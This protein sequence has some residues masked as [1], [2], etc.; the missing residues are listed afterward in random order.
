MAATPTPDQVKIQRHSDLLRYAYLG[1]DGQ[2][3]SI[4]EKGDRI[5]VALGTPLPD[6]GKVAALAPEYQELADKTAGMLMTLTSSMTA[7]SPEEKG[8]LQQYFAFNGEM[9]KFA[10]EQ[11]QSLKGVLGKVSK[12]AG[13]DSMMPENPLQWMIDAQHTAT[14]VAANVKALAKLTVAPFYDLFG[15]G[16]N[17][18]DQLAANEI[19]QENAIAIAS[20]YASARQS[21]AE[22]RSHATPL[23]YAIGVATSTSGWTAMVDK[24]VDGVMWVA[25]P[26]MKFLAGLVASL[27]DFVYPPAAQAVRGWINAPIAREN[28]SFVENY[29][30]N[31]RGHDNNRVAEAM[32]TMPKIGGIATDN[33]KTLATGGTVVTRDRTTVVFKPANEAQPTP[34]IAKPTDG[35]LIATPPTPAAAAK[36]NEAH[37]MQSKTAVLLNVANTTKFDRVVETFTGMKPNHTA[38]T[39]AVLG[40]GGV[41]AA[42]TGK[43]LVGGAIEGTQRRLVHAPEARAEAAAKKLVTLEKN[44]AKLEAKQVAGPSKK[45]WFFWDASPETIAARQAKIDADLAAAE[46]KVA[47]TTATLDHHVAS[48]EARAG[49]DF[50]DVKPSAPG[51]EP[52]HTPGVLTKN[53][54]E[55]L[56]WMN[57]LNWTRIAARRVSGGVT[58]IV[59]FGSHQAMKLGRAVGVMSPIAPA[60]VTPPPLPVTPPAPA[61]VAPPAPAPAPPEPLE[62]VRAGRITKLGIGAGIGQVVIVPLAQAATVA[63]NDGTKGEVATAF[64]KGLAEVAVPGV[65]SG[66]KTFTESNANQNGVDRWL[67][68]LSTATGST[69]TVSSGAALAATAGVV[70]APAD[71][72]LIPTAA[73]SG[74]AN[75][76]VGVVHDVTYW[77]GASKQGGLVTG[78]GSMASD[79]AHS[80]QVNR[81]SDW[82][83]GNNVRVEKQLLIRD[84][85]AEKLKSL[86]TDHDGHVWAQEVRDFLIKEGVS[87]AEVNSA[88]AKQLVDKLEAKLKTP[89]VSANSVITDPGI[90]AAITASAN[91]AKAANAAKTTATA[92]ATPML[93]SNVKLGAVVEGKPTAT[94]SDTTLPYKAAAAAP[95]LA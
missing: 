92:A 78:L 12:S 9:D 21:A 26:V 22:E 10:G 27:L 75:L 37:P 54:A 8:L 88:N 33:L 44:V 57:P 90:A 86:D 87:P 59:E 62:P 61:P 19:S 2:Y 91:V 64:G 30:K 28:N 89:T 52:S 84:L 17:L 79:L 93:A 7:L 32:A 46:A 39:A 83:T 67:N 15:A 94:N 45:S 41:T 47:K 24:A 63:L 77:T 42:F 38:L 3:Y 85:D 95:A 49:S 74:L 20:A 82:A 56:N 51:V 70:T 73:A 5:V 76:G 11:L 13:I 68:G 69:F 66:F 1:V 31:S 34:T 29:E 25:S 23:N 16:S 40:V 55:P 58:G 43:A 14:D 50:H 60:V 36:Q 80:K 48:A 81:L 4:N 53:A 35:K 18:Y 65:T 72:V 6:G 71:A